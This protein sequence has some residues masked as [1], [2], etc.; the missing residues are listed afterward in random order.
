MLGLQTIIKNEISSVEA[1]CCGMRVTCVCSCGVLLRYFLNYSRSPTG[2]N[3][4]HAWGVRDRGGGGRVVPCR[5]PVDARAEETTHR[6]KGHMS[7]G[8]EELMPCPAA[9]ADP[10]TTRRPPVPLLIRSP[11]RRRRARTAAGF[12]SLVSRRAA[13][14]RMGRTVNMLVPISGSEKKASTNSRC[15]SSVH[16][17]NH[18][19]R[20]QPMQLGDEIVRGGGGAGV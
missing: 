7:R 13:W 3:K 9:A 14:T 6:C 4:P 2:K 16:R 5:R 19:C 17:R 15:S 20:M 11:V 8:Q 12:G 18:R 10:G 1:C